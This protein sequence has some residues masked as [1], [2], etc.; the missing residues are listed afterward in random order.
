MKSL[1]LL[2]DQVRCRKRVVVAL[3]LV[4]ATQ[5]ARSADYTGTVAMLEVWDNGNVALTLNS[6][7]PTCNQQ[8]VLN[9]S[10]PGFKNLYAAVLAAK[11]SGAPIRVY[12]NGC[13]PAD[14]A[15]GSSYNIPAY[16]YVLD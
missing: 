14:G 12:T 6:S 2:A 9:A 10:S 7:V 5:G 1:P 8:F 13:G 11:K 3:C 4:L 15:G 16:L